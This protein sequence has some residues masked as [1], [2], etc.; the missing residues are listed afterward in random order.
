MTNQSNVLLGLALWLAIAAIYFLPSIIAGLRGKANGGAGVF[1]VNLFLGWTLIGW[2]V[3]FIW[4]FT[5]RTDAEVRLEARRHAEMLAAVSGKPLTAPAR[6]PE[7][8]I[9][10]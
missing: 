10:A 7:P 1:L 5:G 8:E 2:L 6:P 3:A 9:F 4:A